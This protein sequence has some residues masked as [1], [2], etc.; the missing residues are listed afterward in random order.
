MNIC[1]GTF[2]TAWEWCVGQQAFLPSPPLAYQLVL[3]NS[4]ESLFTADLLAFPDPSEVSF[5]PGCG[6]LTQ[7]Q[8]LS[9]PSL[10]GSTIHGNV[11]RLL[12][13]ITQG[14]PRRSE[15]LFLLKAVAEK[16]VYYIGLYSEIVK[17]RGNK[18]ITRRHNS[19]WIFAHSFLF[20][21]F[22]MKES[23]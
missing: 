16:C 4:S 7:R 11:L 23:T 19:C 17:R 12:G 6:L 9:F 10:Q 1:K 22:A 15:S 13:W 8:F 21:R 18:I 5:K 20:L 2:L 14:W 3:L